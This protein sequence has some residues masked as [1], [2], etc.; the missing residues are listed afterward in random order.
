MDET[1]GNPIPGLTY[2]G[3]EWYQYEPGNATRY[4]FRLAVLD[5]P[6]LAKWFSVAGIGGWVLTWGPHHTRG[7]R[8]AVI[9]ADGGLALA[10]FMDV[11]ACPLGDAVPMAFVVAHL[12]G[13]EC[14]LK[15]ADMRQVWDQ[16]KHLD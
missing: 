6:A 16:V 5:T 4:M 3:D 7:Q 12:M 13:V 9:P 8:T 14:D 2:M 15:S 1:R 11:T 10:T